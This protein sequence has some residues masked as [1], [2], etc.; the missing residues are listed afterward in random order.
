MSPRNLQVKKEE[1]GSA[2][3]KNSQ[4]TGTSKREP[5][6]RW[7]EE[8]N[9]SEAGRYRQ[10]LEPRGPVRRA[11]EPG[12]SS[13]GSGRIGGAWSDLFCR[14]D[15]SAAVCRTEGVGGG[16]T[17]AGGELEGCAGKGVRV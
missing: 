5:G 14:E 7:D 15:H 13:V 8:Y 12:F 10:G 4:C 11:Q 16:E 2:G 9:L 3:N 17:G 1:K 6:E